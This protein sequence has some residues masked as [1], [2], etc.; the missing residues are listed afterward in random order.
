MENYGNLVIDA[1]TFTLNSNPGIH[2]GTYTINT[3]ATL[4]RTSASLDYGGTNLNNNGIIAG[5]SSLRMIRPSGQNING[6]GTIENFELENNDGIGLVGGN[7]TITESMNLIEGDFFTGANKVI[8]ED[9]VVV[10]SS[11]LSYVVGNVEWDIQTPGPKTFPVG[12]VDYYAPVTLDPSFTIGGLVAVRTDIN[13]HPDIANSGIDAAKSVNRFWTI[14]NNGL[15]F[16]ECDVN[17]EWQA[18]DVDGSANPANFILAKLDGTTWTLPSGVTPGA[19]SLYVGNLTSFSDFQIGES[20]ECVVSIPDANFKAALLANASINTNIDGEIQ[21]TEASAYTG[22]IDVQNLSI[23]SL[24][25]IEAFTALTQ[26]N[27]KNNSLTSINISSNTALTFLIC[28]E[29][30]IASIDVSSNTAL[31][32][33][34]CS[35]NNLTSL[36]VTANTLLT[37]LNCNTNAINNLNLSLNTSLQTLFCYQNNLTSLDISQNTA[38]IE[39]HCGGNQITSLDA[40][41]NPALNYFL[42]G[43]NQLTSLNIANGNNT[44]IPSGNFSSLNN[45]ALT[46]IMVDNVA[47]ANAN[48]SAGKDAGAVFS[49]CCTGGIVNIPDAN[50]KNALLANA[51]INTNSDLEIQCAE[52][53]AF[54]GTINV[55][56]LGIT[57][58]TGI[59]AF[60]NV[61]ALLCNNNPLAVPLNVSA[62]VDLVQLICHHNNL[63]SLDVSNNTALHTLHC[64]NNNLTSL[65]LSNNPAMFT[66][67][68]NFNSITSLDF[69][70]N[71]VLYDVT[72]YSNALTSVN[73]TNSP[74]LNYLS[75]FQ[76]PLTSLNVTQ[77][78]LLT[79][80]LISYTQIAT[81]DLSNNTSLSFFTCDNGQFTNLDLSNT[82]LD[83]Y[84][85]V[86]NPLLTSLNI[87]NGN[88]SNLTFFN[89]TACPLL[90][91]IQVDNPAYM[92]ANWSSGKDASATYSTV[93]PITP[94]SALNMDGVDDYVIVPNSPSLQFTNGYTLEAWINKNDFG[95]ERIIDKQNVGGSNGPFTFDTYNGLRLIFGTS[96]GSHQVETG[97]GLPLNTWTHVAATADVATGEMKLFVNGVVAASGTFTGTLLNNALSLGIGVGGG[98]GIPFDGT[99]NGKID[100]VRIWN[101]A[102]TQ[103]EIQAAMNCEIT[104]S[105]IGLVAAY[106]FNQGIAG[107]DNASVTSLTDAS[108]NGNNGTLTNFA[109]NGVTSNWV[110]PGGVVTGTSCPPCIVN[111]PDANFKNALLANAAINTNSNLEIECSEAAAYAG[112]IGVEGLGISDLT[113]IEA[114]TNITSLHCYNNQLTSINLSTNTAL[115]GLICSNNQLTSL[116][117]STNTALL[118]LACSGNQLTTLDLSNNTAIGSLQA[119]YNPLTS[120]NLN[121]LTNLTFASLEL[122]QLSSIDLSSNTNLST[123]YLND[124]QLTSLDVSLLTNLTTLTA[125][126]N[127]PLTSI[128]VKNGNNANLTSFDVRFTP[129]L[130]CIQVD[131][132]ANANGYAGWNKDAGATYSTNCSIICIEPAYTPHDATWQPVTCGTDGLITTLKKDDNTNTLYAGGQFINAGNVAGANNIA[133]WDGT[134]WAALNGGVNAVVRDIEIYAGNPYAVGEFTV[135]GAVPANYVARYVG[136]TW[137][138]I[139]YDMSGVP[140]AMAVYEGE[141]YMAGGFTQFSDNPFTATTNANKIVRFNGTTMSNVPGFQNYGVPISVQNTIHAM[142]VYNGEL[143]VA[144]EFNTRRWRPGNYIAKFNGSSWS[145]LGIGLNDYALALEVHNNELYVGGVFTQAGGIAVQ[146]VA[147]WNGSNWSAVGSQSLLNV[148][149][150]KSYNNKIYAGG[151]FINGGTNPQYIAAFDGTDWVNVG[152]SVNNWVRSNGSLR[153]RFICEWK[154]LDKW[155]WFNHIK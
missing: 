103:T 5:S 130:T 100:E 155:K 141:L 99:Y 59:E 18:T 55:A 151:D 111:I 46:C 121:G 64:Y 44:N 125:Q 120:I 143:V 52:A 85:G 83:Y 113:G 70:N 29:N 108:G 118:G 105:E 97:V 114:F 1:G 3:G 51:A 48:W 154:F 79:S 36:D 38:L 19:L 101:K 25:G 72:A 66:L 148:L 152:D 22:T 117:L 137:Q 112:H 2:Q 91:C 107:A 77:N 31:T 110:E 40:S 53:A 56:N 62:N 20:S 106:H 23:T 138:N 68:C 54:S 129:I 146:G 116:N 98:G 150:L 12:D 153:W 119:G 95:D 102:R 35:H 57:N 65:D 26:L 104:N 124:N 49:T 135:A 73:V 16:T 71:P 140:R 90:S 41:Q 131:N 13:D 63:S 142:V 78:P 139:G 33:L 47:Y 136:G 28:S 15:T 132:V 81:V 126:S 9:D 50:F 86:N 134:N 128:N 45:P 6:T 94:A 133:T 127:Y 21:C 67:F 7:Q 149:S 80:L 88:N 24:V 89:A 147:K 8:L 76:N 4:N 60:V 58:M 87:K 92:N 93:C 42:C 43:D 37:T 84:N 30:N 10:T 34:D 75:L 11:V 122:N 27:C 14:T 69:S 96:T 32:F 82:V 115:T 145:T 61:T 74:N 39:V 144:G 123:L 17:F 109:L